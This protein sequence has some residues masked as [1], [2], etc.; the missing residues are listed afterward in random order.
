M[1][2]SRIKKI[3]IIDLWKMKNNRAFVLNV[4]DDVKIKIK[5]LQNDIQ[6]ELKR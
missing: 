5:K 3:L 6:K 2:G 4:Y 1:I